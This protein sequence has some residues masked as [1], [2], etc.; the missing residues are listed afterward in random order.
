MHTKRKT[1]KTCEDAVIA[2]IAHSSQPSTAVHTR[3]VDQP[4]PCFLQGL[5]RSPSQICL[6][7]FSCCG[8]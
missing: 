4:S 3:S 8:F 1:L 2:F 7:E 5:D 6:Q